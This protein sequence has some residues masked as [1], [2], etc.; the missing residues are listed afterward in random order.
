[1]FATPASLKKDYKQQYSDIVLKNA[2]IDRAYLRVRAYD[3]ANVANAANERNNATNERVVDAGVAGIIGGG[4]AGEEYD[5]VYRILVLSRLTYDAPISTAC[6]SERLD[7]LAAQRIQVDALRTIPIIEQ[8]SPAWYE[9]RSRV[10]TASSL[11]QALGLG[12]YKSQ[13]DFIIEKCGYKVVPFMTAPPLIWGTKYEP[14]AAAVYVRRNDATLYDFGLLNHPN[15]SF[16]GASPDGITDIGTMLEIKCPY[17]RKTTG[18]IPQEYFYQIQG[19]LD[20]CDLNECDYIECQFEEYPGFQ[21]FTNDG[22][23]YSADMCEKGVFLEY[24]CNQMSMDVKT[25]Y[26]YGPANVSSQE[27]ETWVTAEMTRLYNTP[28]VEYVKDTY[29]K[30]A[31]YMCKRVFRDHAFMNARYSELEHVWAKITQYRKDRELYDREIDP[32]TV[33]MSAASTTKTITIRSRGKG[34]AVD[35]ADVS[36]TPVNVFQID[37]SKVTSA[38]VPFMAYAFKPHTG[39]NDW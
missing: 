11:A 3:A 32:P 22:D 26:V 29:W 21:S 10:V 23:K 14:V 36:N 6:V 24:R 4:I 9:A 35:V 34:K 13:K 27:I 19:Q 12:K 8:R 31:G 5:L 30:L 15:V 28:G 33:A 1:M 38:D 37:T 20:V 18:E 2:A 16:F 17:R 25:E 39:G 7:T